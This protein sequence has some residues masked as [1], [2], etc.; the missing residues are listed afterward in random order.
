MRDEGEFMNHAASLPLPGGTSGPAGRPILQIHPS[1]RCNLACAHCYSHSSPMAR[2]ELTVPTVCEVISD[3]AAMGYQ[4]VSVSGGEPLIYGGLEEVLAHAKSLGLLTTVTT[5]GFFTEAERLNRLR[6]LV[7]V[8]AISLDGPAAIH[9]EIRGSARAFQRL[10]AGL[11]AVR[12]AG[13]SFGFIHTL[14]RRNWEHLLW[15]AEFAA[16][17]GARLLQI[18]P[19][20][21]AGRAAGQMAGDAPGDDVLAKVY[22]LVFALA[23]RYGDTMKVQLDLLYRDHL[24]AAPELVYAEEPEGCPDPTAAPAECLGLLVLE[25]DGAVVPVSYGFSRRYQLCNVNEQRAVDSWRHYR[26]SGYPAFRTL[27]RQVWEELCAPEA[28]LLSNWHEVIVAR[29]HARELIRLAAVG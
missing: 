23:S 9:N 13:I 29:S 16:E 11:E 2:T 14:T 17:N 21:L 3:A 15:V 18:H 25:P 7:D 5:N 19:L 6:G 26:V 20:E 4:V 1:L 10:E 8:L 12:H 24:R 22:L 27:C 28:P